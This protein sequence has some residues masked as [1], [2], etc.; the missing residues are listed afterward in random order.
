[1]SRGRVE[2]R[3]YW[4]PGCYR[5]FRFYHEHC[6]YC[7]GEVGITTPKRKC[8][9]CGEWSDPDCQCTLEQTRRRYLAKYGAHVDSRTLPGV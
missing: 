2:Y 6:I 9:S 7:G 1:M 8:V 3:V 4:C 5:M